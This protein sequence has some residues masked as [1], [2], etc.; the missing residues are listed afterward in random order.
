MSFDLGVWNTTR[1]LTQEEAAGVWR[2]GDESNPGLLASSSALDAFCAELTAMH[3]E[4]DDIPDEQIDNHELCPWTVA[5][6]RSPGQLIL[7]ITWSRAEYIRKLIHSLARKHALAVYDPQIGRLSYPMGKWDFTLTVE[8][9]ENLEAA[10]PDEVRAAVRSMTPNGGPGFLILEGRAQDYA[11]A[12]GG[13]GAFTVEWREY[14]T[15]GFRHWTAGLQGQPDAGEVAI[16]TNGHVL[17]VRSNERLA[18]GD[19]ETILL[20]YL[21][22]QGRPPQY[23]WRDITASFG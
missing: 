23:A 16:P 13:D 1:R 10:T 15:G 5:I 7:C 11:Q 9:R 8:G 22:G 17:R 20:A 21:A 2:E 3:P 4:I 18:A 6:C 12:A 14:G 19:A